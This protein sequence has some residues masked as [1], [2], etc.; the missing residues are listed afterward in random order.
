MKLGFVLTATA[1][2]A[3]VTLPTDPTFG[4]STLVVA[5]C[6]YCLAWVGVSIFEMF[7]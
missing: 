2:A 1:V 5:G 6:V 4:A 7:S 3:A